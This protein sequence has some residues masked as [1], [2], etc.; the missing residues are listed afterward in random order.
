MGPPALAS[1]GGQGSPSYLDSGL[2]REDGRKAQRHPLEDTSTSV[3]TDT[4]RLP[5]NA[6]Q[7]CGA[8]GSHREPCRQQ[9]GAKSGH[10]EQA[11]RGEGAWPLRKA[12]PSEGQ[13]RGLQTLGHLTS[14]RESFQ[15]L[16]WASTFRAQRHSRTC[17]AQGAGASPP[18]TSLRSQRFLAA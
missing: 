12:Q 14:G 16:P 15:I 1:L 17:G 10:W 6:K 3:V 8:A 7:T 13:G 2:V 9:G 11:G 18:P 5:A 4:R